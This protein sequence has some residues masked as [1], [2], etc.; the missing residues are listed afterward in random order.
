MAGDQA[1]ASV[2]SDVKDDTQE[3]KKEKKKDDGVKMIDTGDEESDG[4]A[5]DL[6][7]VDQ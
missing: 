2:S 3:D 4:D 6:K 5:P 7:E 1:A